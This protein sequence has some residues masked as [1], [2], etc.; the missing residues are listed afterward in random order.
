MTQKKVTLLMP[1]PTGAYAK[2]KYG[3]ENQNTAPQTAHAV[4]AAY[5]RKYSKQDL[6]IRT[7]SDQE[8]T[9]LTAPIPKYKNRE[10]K[11]L[12]KL[13]R[14]SDV[15]G[16]TCLFHNQASALKIAAEVKK[17]N[18]AAKI[19]LGGQNVSSH[20][21]AI[22]I[23]T[24]Y[25]TI[26]YIVLREGEEAIVGIVDGLNEGEIPNLAYRRK[27]GDVTFTRPSRIDINDIPLWD[28]NDLMDKREILAVYDHRTEAYTEADRIYGGQRMP[29]LGTFTMRGCQ[30]AVT[31]ISGGRKGPCSFCTTGEAN[32]RTINPE[33]FWEQMLHLYR[34]NGL[35][36]FFIADD[37]LPINPE[38]IHKLRSAMKKI[39][40]ERIGYNFRAY[41]YPTSFQCPG[42][43]QMVRDLREIGVSN[44]FLG[45]ETFDKTTSVLANKDHFG[46]KQI[47]RTLDLLHGYGIDSAIPLMPGLPG[48][49]K[50]S[51][52]LNYKCLAYLLEKYGAKELGNG[53][54]VRVDI[55]VAV[56]FDGTH[57]YNEIS[58]DE[59][60]TK[61]YKQMTGKRLSEDI[62]PDYDVLK[63]VSQT[64]SSLS[65][66]MISDHIKRMLILC[67]K[68]LKPEMIG[69]TCL[70][71][72]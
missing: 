14:D 45:I 46:L 28:F 38:Y 37:I 26:D 43:E 54:L 42:V 19:V 9:D 32:L 58:K 15:L 7:I 17:L 4:L 55:S 21:M 56:P 70:I 49:T 64:I 52:E 48:E 62:A 12:M 35:R 22:K 5:L 16:M 24:Q 71:E 10:I 27:H 47:E 72:E 39:E 6:Q 11:D 69:G 51:L 63:E 61:R 66:G 59:K 65:N 13:C 68:Y 36:D 30:K 34:T 29:R 2:I 1:P 31:G 53:N 50:K 60:V 18:P 23:L 67:S 25:P 44:I 40:S 3:Y 8:V 33:K 41:A 20:S 57:L